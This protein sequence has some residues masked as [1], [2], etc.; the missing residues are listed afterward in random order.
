[1]KLIVF[2]ESRVGGRPYNQDRCG[3]SC[4]KDSTLLILADGMGGIQHGEIA[5]QIVVD[6]VI[7]HFNALAKPKIEH[8]NRFLVN[9]ITTAHHAIME[10]AAIHQLSETPSTTVV[11]ASIQDGMLY[12]CHVGDSRLYLFDQAGLAL[13]SRDHSQIQRMIDQGFISAEA[14]KEHPDRSKIYNC[15]GALLDPEVEI[16]PKMPLED[17]HI[18]MLC[19]DGLW[20]YFEDVELEKAFSLRPDVSISIP[21][22]MDIAERR[23]EGRGDNLTAVSL[24]IVDEVLMG[25]KKSPYFVDTDTLPDDSNPKQKKIQQ[26]AEAEIIMELNNELDNQKMF[27]ELQQIQKKHK[28]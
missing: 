28:Y 14:I 3:V 18:L 23:G 21:E 15:L 2:Q 24:T 10:Y 13:R 1:M 12:W 16:G 19:S 17:G 26:D 8:P 7:K 5:A 25:K 6:H 11:A 9:V 27:E 4:R 20:G 22:L